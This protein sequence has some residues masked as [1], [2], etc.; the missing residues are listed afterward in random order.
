MKKL[1]FVLVFLSGLPLVFLSGCSS[2]QTVIDRFNIAQFDNNEYAM[3]NRI[4]TIASE[5]GKECDNP[6]IILASWEIYNTAT[7]LKN[8]SQYIPKNDQSYKPISQLYEMT[9]ELND[10][11]V[12]TG[13]VNVKY[14]ELKLQSIT[15]SAESIQ[16]AIAKRPRP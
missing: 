13:K 1:L 4:R 16:K 14:C 15:T 9:K 11:Y 2:I 5:S 6:K 3:V 7:E 8:Y 12:G 10:K